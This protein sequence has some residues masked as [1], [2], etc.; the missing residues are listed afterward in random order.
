VTIFCGSTLE[1]LSLISIFC[2]ETKNNVVYLQRVPHNL[3]PTCYHAMMT[4]CII[5]HFLV[6]CSLL[7]LQHVVVAVSMLSGIPCMYKMLNYKIH[8]ISTKIK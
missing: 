5:T 3:E 6:V 4:F 8:M 7:L 1:V 2:T